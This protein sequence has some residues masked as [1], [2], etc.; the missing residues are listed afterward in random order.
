[1]NKK[2][3]QIKFN[4]NRTPRQRK[5]N[6]NSEIMSFKQYLSPYDKDNHWLWL[7]KHTSVKI[8]RYLTQN[9]YFCPL[10]LNTDL[11]QILIT[12]VPFG[13]TLKALTIY[14]FILWINHIFQ[15]IETFFHLNE[16]SSHYTTSGKFLITC[17]K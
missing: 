6:S 13:L 11:Y 3:M 2:W 10:Q 15:T 8:F 7:F 9:L 16:C 12:M 5:W 14:W 17:K 1:M 4:M